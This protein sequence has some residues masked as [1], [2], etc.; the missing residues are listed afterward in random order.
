M[1]LFY[2]KLEGLRGNFAAVNLSAIPL[3]LVMGL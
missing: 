2:I 1:W 3:C